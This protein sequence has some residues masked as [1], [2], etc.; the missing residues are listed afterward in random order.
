MAAGNEYIL[1][2]TFNWQQRQ[3]KLNVELY[4]IS[5]RSSMWRNDNHTT[6]RRRILR[7]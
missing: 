5:T 1:L 4:F 7:F 3:T 2:Q 6:W